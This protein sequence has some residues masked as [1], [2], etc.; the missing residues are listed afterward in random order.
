MPRTA[1]VKS[2][3][4]AYHVLVR[5]KR[6]GDI[7]HDD[8]D[9]T[10]FLERLLK[11]KMSMG[12][13]IFAYAVMDNHAHILLQEGPFSIGEVM[14]RL[15][16]G[17]TFYYNMKYESDGGIFHDRYKSEPVET[18]EAMRDTLRQIHQ[19]PVREGRPIRS[20]TSFSDYESVAVHCDTLI[21]FDMF[22]YDNPA[23]AR[24][25]FLAHVSEECEPGAF[26]VERRKLTDA[27]AT[28]LIREA[29]GMEDITQMPT[30]HRGR[31][32]KIFK[33]LKEQGCTIRQLERLTGCGR[34]SI[35]SA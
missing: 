32:K 25:L 22:A 35:Y 17:Y 13:S 16:T 14:K 15:T 21:I 10:E 11:L 7:F 31:R 19:N 2:D 29:S 8:E 6:A 18:D 9:K 28:M 4:G 34:G 12:Y 26:E 1:R 3:T 23:K 33:K 27:E 20:F 5:G 24:E 30:L